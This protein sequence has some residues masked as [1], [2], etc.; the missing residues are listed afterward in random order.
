M[1]LLRKN[2]LVIRFAKH[3]LRMKKT[4]PVRYFFVSLFADGVVLGT[5]ILLSV[6]FVFWLTLNDFTTFESAMMAMC[7]V[8]M[9]VVG[10]SLATDSGNS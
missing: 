2:R 1:E 6:A 7:L 5:W 8:N 9:N 4:H 10:I 3:M